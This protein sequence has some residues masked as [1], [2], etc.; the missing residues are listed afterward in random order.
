M[1]KSKIYLD[2]VLAPRVNMRVFIKRGNVSYVGDITDMLDESTAVVKNC[3]TGESEQEL[4]KHAFV[5]YVKRGSIIYLSLEWRL[6]LMDEDINS[7][8]FSFV[9]GESTTNKNKA[10]RV[11]SYA[12][13]EGDNY[14]VEYYHTTDF[15]VIQQ[16]IP[17][18]HKLLQWM[19]L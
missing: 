8:E 1:Y 14:Y 13:L 4:V 15:S 19:I 16:L 5:P 6:Y 10:I 12:L 7:K 17:K 18:N 11:M 3:K 9:I 2:P